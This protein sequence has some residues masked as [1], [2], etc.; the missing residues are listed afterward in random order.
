M[1]GEIIR[2]KYLNTSHPHWAAQ[3][4]G[5]IAGVIRFINGSKGRMTQLKHELAAST[6]RFRQ[7]YQDESVLLSTILEG[8]VPCVRHTTAVFFV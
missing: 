3:G 2:Q 7:G 6:S 4:A 5:G 8:A 1:G